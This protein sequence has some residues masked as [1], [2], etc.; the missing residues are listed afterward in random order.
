MRIEE[1]LEKCIHLS[2]KEDTQEFQWEVFHQEWFRENG[3]PYFFLFK[4][5]LGV[6]NTQYVEL[7]SLLQYYSRN[8]NNSEK[9]LNILFR[10]SAMFK[11]TI[12]EI[13][14]SVLDSRVEDKNKNV[15]NFSSKYAEVLG[16]TV[17]IDMFYCSAAISFPP[18]IEIDLERICADSGYIH[19]AG[20]SIFVRNI[21]K[22]RVAEFRETISKHLNNLDNENLP[23]PFIVY[24]HEDFTGY[25][26]GAKEQI[27]RGI[28]STKVYLEKMSMGTYRLSEV[29]E[30]MRK[31][32]Q[33]IL[34]IP[35]P[36]P[37]SKTHKF[38]NDRSLWLICERSLSQANPLNPG[39]RRYYICYEQL[40]KNE[41]P[42]YLFDENKPAW[43]SH[44]TLPHSLTAALLNLTR[45]ASN[46]E[47]ICDPFGGTGTT[48]L[49]AKRL[50]INQKIHS[51]DISKITPL[52]IKDNLRFFLSDSKI[53]LELESDLLEVKKTIKQESKDPLSDEIQAKFEFDIDQV[54]KGA[55]GGYLVA[56][57]LLSLLKEEQPN[58]DQEFTYSES[59]INDLKSQGYI[60]RFMFYI[61]LRAEFRYQGG[62]RRGSTD[63]S[64]AFLKSLEEILRQVTELRE[65]RERIEKKNVGSKADRYTVFQGRY[66]KEVISNLFLTNPEELES[67]LE[68]EIS[69]KDARKLK[70]NSIDVIICDPP[71]GFNTTENQSDLVTLYSEFLDHAI[72]ALKK[73]GHLIVCLPAESYTGRDLPFCTH[74]GMIISQVMV[75]AAAQDRIAYR[76]TRTI[77]RSGFDPPYYWEAERALRRAILHFR[78][79]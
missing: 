8:T 37:Y 32:W 10:D 73:N 43:K 79:V 41:N 66:S 44:T 39:R 18:G 22:A 76:P 75:K 71:Y 3:K 5:H 17:V 6:T 9:K 34:D 51:S 12:S 4:K 62:I 64:K 14:N 57:S 54:G 68:S 16:S 1:I 67:H 20:Y 49:E 13:L 50:G 58:E 38:E 29:I 52:M 21:K 23:I 2:I 45:S 19:S 65:S 77:P 40:V 15:K 59:F 30:E 70:R 63:F 27:S 78:F 60:T 42:F 69:V 11:E 35:L 48:W 46:Q 31:T 26:T 25:D 74:S 56:K 28:D 55:V 36:G 33:G 47:I 7:F 24:A 53:L 72:K 61:A